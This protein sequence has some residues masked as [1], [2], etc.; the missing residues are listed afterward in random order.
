MPSRQRV[1]AWA[2]P[3]SV[4]GVLALALGASSLTLAVPVQAQSPALGDRH[5]VTQ[6][7]AVSALARDAALRASIED[8]DVSTQIPPQRGLVGGAVVPNFSNVSATT[9]FA[10]AATQALTIPELDKAPQGAGGALVQVGAV[11]TNEPVTVWVEGSATPLLKV[12]AGQVASTS[13][14]IKMDSPFRVRTSAPTKVRVLVRGWIED[15]PD[16]DVPAGG[17]GIADKPVARLDTPRERDARW[18]MADE[19]RAVQLTGLGGVP[20]RATGVFVDA[21]MKP[22]TQERTR[23]QFLDG[24]VWRDLTQLSTTQPVSQLLIIPVREDGTAVLRSTAPVDVRLTPL[25][26]LSAGEGWLE[27]EGAGG[28]VPVRPDAVNTGVVGVGGSFDVPALPD[29]VEVI[30]VVSGQATGTGMLTLESGKSLQRSLKLEVRGPSSTILLLPEANEGA[31]LTL[32]GPVTGEANVVGYLR[33]T[34]PTRIR[35]R[36]ATDIVLAPSLADGARVNLTTTGLLAVTG[37]VGSPRGIQDVVVSVPGLPLL[38]ADVDHLAGTFA[39]DLALPQGAQ[40]VTFTATDSDGATRSVTREVLVRAADPYADILAEGAV[41]L[42]ASQR[43]RIIKVTSHTIVA[44]RPLLDRFG[45]PLQAGMVVLSE[46]FRASAEGLSRFVKAVAHRGSRIVYH[47]EA[48]DLSEI[49]AQATIGVEPADPAASSPTGRDISGEGT[50]DY[51]K[52]ANFTKKLGSESL[53]GRVWVNAEAS[54]FVSMSIFVST[55]WFSGSL[56]YF[57][58]DGWHLFKADAG[59]EVDLNYQNDLYNGSPFTSTIMAGPVPIVIKVP[60]RVYLD[61]QGHAEVTA[62]IEKTL[63]WR[64]L[65]TREEKWGAKGWRPIEWTS[66]WEPDNWRITGNYSVDMKL[67]LEAEPS[68]SLAEAV[69][70]S[71]PMDFTLIGLTGA[72]EMEIGKDKPFKYTC[73]EPLELYSKLD[74]G[75]NI[76]ALKDWKSWPII[77]KTEVTRLQWWKQSNCGG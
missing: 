45:R 17:V 65:Y 26:W 21:F 8:P 14:I 38:H 9:D 47:T 25:A 59:V 6:A 54:G 39:V 23:L 16:Q 27:P 57:N 37:R 5:E 68:L 53:S 32:T 28:F 42:A 61:L 71:V 50:A 40:S 1:K 72:G 55:G 56:E 34:D 31:R 49:F 43:G 44:K 58:V 51:E 33:V 18:L 62:Y 64:L 63:Q 75:L 29:S 22:A 2:R 73:T 13:T 69:G 12:P 41:Q 60:V 52:K 46:P 19:G 35:A 66:D 10:G 76:T 4:V 77:D 67:G 30:A 7:A 3:R 70:V 11:S 74:M 20:T 24:A 15:D 36:S 48:P